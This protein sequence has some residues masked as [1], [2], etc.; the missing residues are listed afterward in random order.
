MVGKSFVES[1]VGL[2]ILVNTLGLSNDLLEFLGNEKV[3]H[4]DNVIDTVLLM[5]IVNTLQEM[6]GLLVM[7]KDNTSKG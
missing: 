3:Y 4:S 1:P 7:I 6:Q 5:Q 2:N